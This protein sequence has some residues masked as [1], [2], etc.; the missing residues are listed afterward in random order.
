MTNSGA[1]VVSVIDT[2]TNTVSATITGITD[3]YG[4]AVSPL[5]I[6]H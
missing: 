3:P 5:P 2:S 6:K 4:V 1:D